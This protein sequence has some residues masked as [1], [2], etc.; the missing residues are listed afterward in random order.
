MAVDRGRRRPPQA[1]V[2]IG[3]CRAGTR[4]D[5]PR[6]KPVET[7]KRATRLLDAV[8]AALSVNVPTRLAVAAWRMSFVPSVVMRQLPAR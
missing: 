4:E 8:P 5:A 2:D 7:V 1:D 6:A 3:E